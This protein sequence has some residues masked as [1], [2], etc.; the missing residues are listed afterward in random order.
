MNAHFQ[1][2]GVASTEDLGHFI[3][4]VKEIPFTVHSHNLV[5]E[6]C[7]IVGYDL[8]QFIGLGD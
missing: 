7:E 5:I 8:N 6:H 3:I 1:Q 4:Q 2:Q